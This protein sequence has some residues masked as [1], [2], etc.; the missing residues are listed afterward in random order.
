MKYSLIF[1]IVLLIIFGIEFV[2]KV[3]NLD[4]NFTKK[5]KSSLIF[6]INLMIVLSIVIKSTVLYN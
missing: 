5:I 1:I 4:G 6:R 2:I 3:K